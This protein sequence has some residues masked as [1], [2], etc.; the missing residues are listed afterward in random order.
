MNILFFAAQYIPTV[1]GV[2]RY[3]NNLA[4]ELCKRGHSVTVVTSSLA[5][6]KHSE[7]TIEGINIVRLPSF[8]LMNG[9]FP[10][11]KP[12]KDFFRLTKKVLEQK[13]DIAVIN[14]KLYPLSIY[15]SFKAKQH[16]I[17]QIEIEH[18]TAHLVS[19]KGLIEKLF[20]AVE[21]TFCALL[22]I[23]CKDFYG[24]SKACAGWLSHF[25]ITAKGE[26]YN[27]VNP[28]EILATAKQSE[29]NFK[30]QLNLSDDTPVISYAGRLIPDKGV[31]VMKQA[32]KKIRQ[33]VPNAVMVLAGDGECRQQLSGLEAEG[34]YLVGELRYPDSLALIEQSD[35]FL[36]PTRSEGFS[37][38]V[39]E[40]AA[41]KTFIIT[42]ATGGSPELIIN[43]DYGEI[44]A[45]MSIEQ[46]VEKTVYALLNKPKT[47]KAS[48][49][50]FKR[51]C[52]NFT[53]EK[54]ADALIEVINNNKKTN[55]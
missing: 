39:L 40:A 29:I 11:I 33:T 20:N 36:M 2:E 50:C 16:G 45:D 35:I 22:K 34:L 46:T 41:L 38:T 37:C 53:F 21:H 31:L 55:Q 28:S 17:F 1:G 9:R 48:E 5:G 30:Q 3:T 6:L 10:V 8:S 13:F 7:T 54:T 25:G 24:V 44:L 52:E 19:N 47:K 49:N 12:N 51:L 4:K 42:T 26:L 15:A 14:T 43:S 18:G 27:A 32:L 23:N